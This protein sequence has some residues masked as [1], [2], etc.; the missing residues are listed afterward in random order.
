MTVPPLGAKAIVV[1]SNPTSQALVV[2]SKKTREEFKSISFTDQPP[3]KPAAV[4]L[5]TSEQKQL[6]PPTLPSAKN[7]QKVATWTT[8]PTIVK[9]EKLK[10]LPG[11]SSSPLPKEFEQAIAGE[12]DTKTALDRMGMNGSGKPLVVEVQKLSDRQLMRL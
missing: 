1:S 9:E 3:P 6:M 4:L 7:I 10:L 12:I 5:S 11:V 8:P 2:P